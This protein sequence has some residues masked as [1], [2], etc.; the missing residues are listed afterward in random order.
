MRAKTTRSSPMCV[1]YTIQL[2]TVLVT[3]AASN[4]Q[5]ITVLSGP[6]FSP[7]SNAPLAGVLALTTDA[8]SQVTVSVT[9]GTSS[10]QRNF[11][12]YGTNHSLTLLGFKANRTNQ[13]TVTVRDGYRNSYTAAE[14]VSFVTGPLPA[15]M[16]AFIVRT[17]NPAQM[18]PGYTLFRVGN[19][20]TYGAYVTIV[21]SS[22]QVV[23]YGASSET[24][25]AP[26]PFPTPADVLQ[27]TNGDL[28]FPL[29]DQQGFSE[30]DMLGQPVTTWAAP[31][32]VD[33]HENLLTDHG[34]ILYLTDYTQNINSFPTSATDPNAPTQTSDVT[35]A[36][37]V[38]IS[39]TQ[40][41][42]VNSWSIIDMLDPYRIDYLCFELIPAFGIDPEHANAIIDDTADDSLIV[43]LRNQDAVIKF[44]RSG[45]LKWILGP[46]D[47][48]GPEWQPYLLTPVGTN[49]EWNY[50]QHA[51]ILTPQ[52]T[53]LLYDDGNYRAVPYAPPV[54][55]QYNYS[56][57]VEFSV[58]ETN[59]E[60]SQVWQFAD[61]N[62]DPLYTGALGNAS[63][64]PQTSNVLVTFGYV[65]Y[66]NG[67]HPDPVAPLATIA[68]IKEVTH[69]SNPSVV[70]DLEL[71]DPA[72]TNVNSGGFSVYRSHGIPD[73][74]SHLAVPVA[75]LTVQS[76]AGHA[77]LRFSADSTRS[78]VVQASSDLVNWT[79]IGMASQ[80]DP[81]GDFSF[82]DQARGTLPIQFYRVLTQ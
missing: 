72:N 43:S 73:L 76:Q 47:N 37:V 56:R 48:W 9:D 59:M 38:E 46:P 82:Q 15:D 11:F 13:I 5:A 16:P 31:Y 70:F 64:L 68:R 42:V 62:N 23:W 19:Q 27:L 1:R 75:D 24:G 40:P 49:F 3:F 77:L 32:P 44:S 22:G 52:G 8:A 29:S 54:L 7:S 55:D 53:L 58:D 66:E 21:D 35:C 74:Y 30:V 79:E 4:S 34:T 28:F 63:W 80:D 45:Q 12:D 10:W 61:T 65:S 6:T 57:A 17:N 26:G 36:R 50:A 60:V 2:A 51:P 14:P 20:T 25:G 18:E 41:D 39:T 78:Y 67:A 71:S 33:A 69:H 81:T